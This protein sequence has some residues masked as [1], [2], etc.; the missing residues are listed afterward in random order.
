[1]RGID[2]QVDGHG[3]DALVGPSD[4][5]S[6][7]LDLLPDLIKICELFALAVEE[8]GVFWRSQQKEAKNN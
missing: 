7:C 3:G 5:V 2:S 4:A 1:M 8:L 6:L